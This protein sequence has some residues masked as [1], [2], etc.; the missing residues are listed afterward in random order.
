MAMC[1]LCPKHGSLIQLLSRSA[2]TTFAPLSVVMQTIRC[3][4]SNHDAR[5][6]FRPWAMMWPVWSSGKYEVCKQLLLSCQYS[7]MKC[8]VKE[9]YGS[10]VLLDHKSVAVAK[11]GTFC[12]SFIRVW[13]HESYRLGRAVLLKYFR[14][15]TVYLGSSVFTS[16]LKPSLSTT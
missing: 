3:S 16:C 15:G 4:L 9:R 7:S 14:P 1:S 11:C 8:T 2:L 5:A 12:S 6:S 10:D 13:R